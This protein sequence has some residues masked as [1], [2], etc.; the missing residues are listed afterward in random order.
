MEVEV[1]FLESEL[2]WI[3]YPAPAK[4]RVHLEGDPKSVIETLDV[5]TKY[6]VLEKKWIRR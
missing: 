2:N 4:V 6:F 5:L 3:G 1:E